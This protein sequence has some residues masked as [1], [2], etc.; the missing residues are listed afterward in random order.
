MSRALSAAY[1][2]AATVAKHWRRFL[3]LELFAGAGRIATAWRNK[4][5]PSLG[6]EISKFPC[7]DVVSSEVM[8]VLY[9]WVSSR[10]GQGM[11]IAIPCFSWSRAHRFPNALRSSEQPLGLDDI[12]DERALKVKIWNF[13]AKRV[14]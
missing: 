12:S 8:S 6:F 11:W 10:V 4:G 5:I 3:F 1:V 9:G 13:E 2:A 14:F 7:F